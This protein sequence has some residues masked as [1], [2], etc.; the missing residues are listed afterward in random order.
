MLYTL[1]I[2]VSTSSSKIMVYEYEYYIHMPLTIGIIIYL[3]IYKFLK[4]LYI[5]LYGYTSSYIPSIIVY[6][7]E[8]QTNTYSG[9]IF[10]ICIMDGITFVYTMY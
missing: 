4:Y 8:K 1:I 6:Y 10:L 3:Y 7:I 2:N 9:Y 5:I